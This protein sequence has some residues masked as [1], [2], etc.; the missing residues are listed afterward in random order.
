MHEGKLARGVLH[1]VP[2]CRSTACRPPRRPDAGHGGGH[3]DGEASSTAPPPH[4]R[5]WDRAADGWL[6]P[7]S[8]GA[9]ARATWSSP[10][11]VVGRLRRLL[12]RR[13]APG[14][15]HHGDQPAAR[16]GRGGE[17]RRPAPGRR[18]WW[19]TDGVDAVGGRRCARMSC[20]A[21]RARLPVLVPPPRP[22]RP[23]G[24]RVDQRHD[25]PCPRGGVR[26]RQ[27]GAMARGAGALSAYADRRLSPLPSPMWAT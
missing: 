17:H 19:S 16:P 5:R 8:T 21:L 27:P 1:S 26:P 24:H 4:V 12:R 25:G 13:H 6:R 23:R 7:W 14:R 15:D 11:A 20:G 3:A 9:W 2:R 22:V 10:A 18:W